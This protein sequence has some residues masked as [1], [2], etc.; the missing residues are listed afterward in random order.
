M[1]PIYAYFIGLSTNE[2]F[3]GY[4]SLVAYRDTNFK[5]FAVYQ[6]DKKTDK[7]FRIEGP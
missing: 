4:R 1:G 6:Y 5:T 7:Y 3:G 2:R